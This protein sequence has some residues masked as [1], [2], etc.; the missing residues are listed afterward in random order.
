M[1]HFNRNEVI[2]M[3]EKLKTDMKKS[4]ILREIV[5]LFYQVHHEVAEN[6]RDDFCRGR[7]SAM[8]S[9]LKNVKIYEVEVKEEN[10][11]EIR[12]HEHRN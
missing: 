6:P 10:E 2:T 7:E 3:K 4:E 12:N 1:R 5:D 8:L 9:L 11:H